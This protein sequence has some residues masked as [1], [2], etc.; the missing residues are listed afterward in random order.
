M[1]GQDKT[2]PQGRGP[3]T[4]GGFGPCAGEG[5]GFSR[6]GRGLGFGRGRGAAGFGRGLGRRGAGLGQGRRWTE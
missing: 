1:P 3:L 4:G 6:L 2:G 5:T